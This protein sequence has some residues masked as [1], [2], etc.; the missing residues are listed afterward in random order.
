VPC[1]QGEGRLILPSPSEVVWNSSIESSVMAHSGDGVPPRVEPMTAAPK[2]SPMGER[3]RSPKRSVMNSMLLKRMVSSRE[4][5]LHDRR[6]PFVAMVSADEG[7]IE[8]SRGKAHNKSP[9]LVRQLSVF[10]AP[11]RYRVV[12]IVHSCSKVDL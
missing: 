4:K 3:H 12:K 7:T 2:P 11:V 5:T 1:L 8:M 6:S 9:F 10:F